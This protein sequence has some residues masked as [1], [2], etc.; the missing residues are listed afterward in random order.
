MSLRWRITLGLGAIVAAVVLV[1]VAAAY[2]TTAQRLGDTV[3]ESLLTSAQR[4]P[5]FATP[6][7]WTGGRRPVS[8]DRPAD[9]APAAMP[10]A[11]RQSADFSW[12]EGCPPGGDFEPAAAAERLDA[13]GTVTSCVDGGPTIPVDGRDRMLA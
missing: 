4:L 10:T 2:F 1:G 12:P 13:D 6:R 9:R 5:A 3:D 11:R 8:P 7:L